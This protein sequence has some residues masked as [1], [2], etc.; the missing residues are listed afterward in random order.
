LPPADLAVVPIPAGPRG[1]YS[2]GGGN[3]FAFPTYATSAE[4]TAALQFLETI[5]RAPVVTPDAVAAMNTSAHNLY[6]RGITVIQDGISVWDDPEYNKA[7]DDAIAEYL[8]VDMRF[9][10]DYYET[11]KR[12]GNIRNEDGGPLTQDLYAE[13]TKCLQAVLTD[14]NANVNALLDIAQRNFQ[15]MLDR[16][17]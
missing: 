2:L 5:G 6:D 13:L 4:V 17:N 15:A 14:Q 11:V 10:N 9:Y 3:I 1:Q 12:P 8:N 16:L 7:R